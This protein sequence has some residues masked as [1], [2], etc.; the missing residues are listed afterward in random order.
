VLI[1]KRAQQFGEVCEETDG[2]ERLA[3]IGSVGESGAVERYG[4]WRGRGV[5]QRAREIVG[6]FAGVLAQAKAPGVMKGGV[7]EGTQGG[8]GDLGVGE[9]GVD[10][11]MEVLESEFDKRMEVRYE[12]RCIVTDLMLCALVID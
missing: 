3:G 11:L 4:V 12:V 1:W 2:D 7:G 10:D 9:V 5:L 6:Y 8:D